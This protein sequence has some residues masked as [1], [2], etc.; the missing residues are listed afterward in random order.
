MSL[1]WSRRVLVGSAR[2]LALVSLMLVVVAQIYADDF[3]R[4]T[5]ITVD[6]YGETTTFRE[7]MEWEN[8]VYCVTEVTEAL[9]KRGHFDN[10]EDRILCFDTRREQE[11]YFFDTHPDY[12]PQR[13]GTNAPRPSN[14]F[15]F[16]YYTGWNSHATDVSSDWH[17][18][19][20]SVWSVLENGNAA[21][22]VYKNTGCTGVEWLIAESHFTLGS[23]WGGNTIRSIDFF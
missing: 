2:V 21:M 10:T 19:G 18:F 8:T 20:Y 1:K 14:W 4:R 12:R 17:D 7:V 15:S 5:D 16:Y 22:K 6:Y 23:G 3:Q 13:P 11:T 9:N